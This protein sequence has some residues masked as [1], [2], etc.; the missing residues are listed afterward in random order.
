[1][2]GNENKNIKSANHT[3]NAVELLMSLSLFFFFLLI[4]TSNQIK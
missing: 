1:M 4:T 3:E 2:K